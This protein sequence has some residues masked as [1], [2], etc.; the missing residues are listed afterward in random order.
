MKFLE[1]DLE[2]IIYNKAIEDG[3]IEKLIDNGLY[4]FTEESKVIRQP[5][6]GA[7]G[8][9]DLISVNYYKFYEPETITPKL[10][11]SISVVELKKDKI[12]MSAFLQAVGYSKGIKRYLNERGHDVKIN[13]T[14][15]GKSIDLE[16]EVCYIPDIFPNVDFYTYDFDFN[17]IIFNHQG[18]FKLT[19]EKF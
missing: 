10:K 11:F 2:D 14:L 7:Y 5:R 4:C 3:G 19:N 1:K 8:I 9:A 6:I 13:I 17:G 12:S 18:E 16:S 15:I